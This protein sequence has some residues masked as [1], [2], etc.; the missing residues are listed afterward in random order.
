MDPVTIILVFYAFLFMLTFWG[1][2]NFAVRSI[3]P[4]GFYHDHVTNRSVM[5]ETTP[6]LDD[7]PAS[8]SSGHTSLSRLHDQFI[9]TLPQDSAPTTVAALPT[10]EVDFLE[11]YRRPESPCPERQNHIEEATL[12]DPEHCK[13]Y[14]FGTEVLSQLGLRELQQY[15]NRKIAQ[16]WL[17]DSSLADREDYYICDVEY[18]PGNPRCFYGLVVRSVYRNALVLQMYADALPQPIPDTHPNMQLYQEVFAA[19]FKHKCIMVFWDGR[20]DRRTFQFP[21]NVD[22][23]DLA[24]GVIWGDPA[25]QYSNLGTQAGRV[26]MAYRGHHA[27]QYETDVQLH[28]LHFLARH[29]A[30]P[31]DAVLKSLPYVI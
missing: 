5:N 17:A 30:K 9:D 14:V 13:H 3:E 31:L 15:H 26:N 12:V 11:L 27:A 1:L 23:R 8:P 10:P 22:C 24:P 28:L 25:G 7:A 20:N 4:A 16:N 21:S 18:M 29:R 6:L 2:S 19:I